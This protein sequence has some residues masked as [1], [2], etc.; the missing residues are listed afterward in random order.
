MCIRDRTQYYPEYRIGGLAYRIELIALKAHCGFLLLFLCHYKQPPLLEH[1]AVGVDLGHYF[2]GYHYHY[3][4]Y[5]ALIEARRRGHAHVCQ[6]G[7]A[8]VDVGCLLYTS[9]CV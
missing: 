9:R 3:Q 2:V 5:Y 7:Q 8:A 4:S 1:C 6:L